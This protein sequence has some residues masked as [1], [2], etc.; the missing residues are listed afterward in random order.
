MLGPRPCHIVED[1]R[2]RTPGLVYA[3]PEPVRG[4]LQGRDRS[5]GRPATR[6]GAAEAPVDSRSG[7]PRRPHLPGQNRRRSGLSD[8]SRRTRTDDGH[9]AT[10]PTARHG[11]TGWYQPAS[12]FAEAL[13]AQTCVCDATADEFLWH[14]CDDQLAWAK[15]ARRRFDGASPYLPSSSSRSVPSTPTASTWTRAW[16]DSATGSGTSARWPLPA[17]QGE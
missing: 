1:E 14:I 17:A 2:D 13:E 16:P 15:G 10:R 3:A 6:S 4:A 7:V 11:R 8:Q 9:L 5:S 12:V